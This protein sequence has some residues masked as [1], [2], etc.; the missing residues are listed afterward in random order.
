MRREATTCDNRGA[1]ATL[2]PMKRLLSLGAVLS[3]S[4]PHSSSTSVALAQSSGQATLRTPSATHPFT[5]V[6]QSGQTYV[7]ASE[8]VAGLGGTMTPDSSGYKVTVGNVTARLRS[9]QPLRRRARRAHRDAGAADLDRRQAVRA[10][11]VLPGLAREGVV[12]RRGV[13]RGDALAGRASRAARCDRRAGLRRERAG[14]LEDRPH[15][16]RAGGVRDRE[17][18]GRVRRPL[19][20]RR[21][22]RRSRSSRTKIR[23]GEASTFTGSDLRI[24][25]TARTSSATRISSRIRRAS[26]STSA[27][28]PRPRRGHRSRCNRSR[29]AAGAAG[30][31]HDR[32]RSGTRRKRSR[33]G[34]TERADG[35]R[36]HAAIARKL[37]AS[38]S[39]KTVGAR[40]VLTRED[41]S[42]VSLDQRTALANQYKADLFLSVHLN[43]AR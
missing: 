4:S 7:S 5:Y 40:V 24:Q 39:A 22:A 3:V 36:H 17:R 1:F 29:Q 10:V 23:R 15:A 43:A 8:V 41:D 38:L 9:R 14:D 28:A 37:A 30:H 16:Q 27:R 35:E 2:R 25:L 18:A 34:R 33:R 13:G 31:P 12:D 42:V 26:C 6:E 19:P 21:C 11:A 32:D 20:R